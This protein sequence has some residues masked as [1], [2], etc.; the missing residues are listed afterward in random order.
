MLTKCCPQVSFESTAS[1]LFQVPYPVSPLLAALTKTPGCIP[2]LP[3]LEL[4]DWR[5][6][7]ERRRGCD[8]IPP[9]PNWPEG[10]QVLAFA[11]VLPGRK[12]TSVIGSQQQNA[13]LQPQR[14]NQRSL[15]PCKS[16]LPLLVGGA[17][18]SWL[19]DSRRRDQGKGPSS[20]HRASCASCGNCAGAQDS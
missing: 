11:I 4:P 2:T 19:L 17:F 20:A 15:R 3:I 6:T 14:K 12:R 9:V 16:L 13:P 10:S 18:A 7:R 5:N 8:A 1:A